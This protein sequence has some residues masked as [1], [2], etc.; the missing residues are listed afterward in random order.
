[1]LEVGFKTD[2]GICLT[3]YV[4]LTTYSAVCLSVKPEILTWLGPEK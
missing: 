1:M 4:K 3:N 2:D